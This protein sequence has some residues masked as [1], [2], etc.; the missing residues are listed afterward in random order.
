MRYSNPSSHHLR[1]AQA[2]HKKVAD[3]FRLDSS[4]D[5]PKFKIGDR[6]WLQKHNVK[7]TRPC[8][9]LD[10][11]WLGPFGILDQIN[12]VTFRLDLIFTHAYTSSIPRVFVIPPPPPI[13]LVDGPEFEVEAILD[14]KI[15][16][17]KLYYLVD[18][19]GYSPSDRTWELAENLSNAPKLVAE[20]HQ[21]YPHKPDKNSCTMTRHQRRGMVS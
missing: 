3:R 9:K 16:R 12:D 8:D 6:V 4:P 17:N 1:D 11:Q 7:T 15:M 19:L 10:Y 21:R 18:W 13:Q 20:F 2:T 5:N 14:S